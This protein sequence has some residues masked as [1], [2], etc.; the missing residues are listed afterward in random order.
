[1][2]V[3]GVRL[4]TSLELLCERHRTAPD[5]CVLATVVA[6]AGSTYRKAGARMTI[7]PDGRLTGLLSGGCLEHD[8]R[9]HAANV[10]A[11][12]APRIVE[13]DMRGPDDLVWG[14]GAGCEGAMRILLEPAGPGSPAALA[15]AHAAECSAAGVPT[16]LAVVHEGR[17]LGTRNRSGA[18]AARTAAGDA[19]DPLAAALADAMAD[20]LAAGESRRWRGTADGV[21]HEAW[22]QVLPP[23]PRLL[24]CGAGPDAEPVVRL[25]RGLGWA[26]T[27]VDHR[28]AYLDATRFAGADLR[29]VDPEALADAVAPSRHVAAVVMSHHLPSDAAYLRALARAREPG[30]VGLLGPRPRRERLAR[31]LGADAAALAGRLRGPVGLDLGAATPEGIALAI[32]AELHAYAAHRDAAPCSGVAPAA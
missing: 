5:G 23:P 31:E 1:M 10:R 4:D 13:Y 7:D 16:V 29:L 17:A 14:L 12:R 9:E 15:L 22:L 8:L 32:V 24:V 26:V 25:A 18:D 27:V 19:T 2:T 6:T 28:P 21:A 11:T 3:P 20:A 30:Y